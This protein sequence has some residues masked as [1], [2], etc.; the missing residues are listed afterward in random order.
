MRRVKFTI[1]V[2]ME[3]RWV[4]SFLGTLALQQRLGGL[5]RSRHVAIFSDGDG[6]YRPK[7]KWDDDLLPKPQR[8]DLKDSVIHGYVFDADK[9]L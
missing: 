9:T 4:P 2:E 3:E 6:D 7:F 5:G 1:E 8:H